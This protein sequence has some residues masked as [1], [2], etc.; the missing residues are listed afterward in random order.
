MNGLKKLKKKTFI[1]YWCNPHN[2]NRD[3]TQKK[4]YSSMY[5]KLQNNGIKISGPLIP[6]I[7]YKR[8]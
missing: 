3:L 6:D 4:N 8:L 2:G 7:I 5:R 1:V